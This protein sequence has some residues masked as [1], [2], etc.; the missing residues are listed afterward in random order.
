MWG[1]VV[2]GFSLDLLSIPCLWGSNTYYL[3][4]LGELT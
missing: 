4:D 3:N 1:G 2:D